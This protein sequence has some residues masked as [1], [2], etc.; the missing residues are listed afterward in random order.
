[1]KILITVVFILL[2]LICFSNTVIVQN[3]N[4]SGSGSLREAISTSNSNDTIRFNSNLIN[5]GTDT[6]ILLSEI[7]FAKNLVFKGLYNSTDTLYISGGNSNRIFNINFPSSSI[8]KREIIIDSLSLINGF[9]QYSGGAI[10]IKYGDAFTIKNSLIQSNVTI[11]NANLDNAMI[12]H[13][14]KYNGDY[15][16][17]SIGDYTELL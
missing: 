2:T 13:H 8:T 15:T 3:T 1:M 11:T 7:S 17:V 10:H 9:S 14:A 5:N 16:S 6:I 4:N 12:G